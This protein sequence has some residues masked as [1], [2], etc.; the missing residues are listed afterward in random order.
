[1]LN[2]VLLDIEM[3]DVQDIIISTRYDD[4]ESLNNNKSNMSRLGHVEKSDIRYSV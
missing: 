2:K 1:M 4:K 3:P